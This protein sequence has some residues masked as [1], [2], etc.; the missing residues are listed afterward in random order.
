M[1]CARGFASL[2]VIDSRILGCG[3]GFIQSW[4]SRSYG[5]S[6]FVSDGYDQRWVSRLYVVYE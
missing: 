4:Y 2:V 1:G 3:G 5:S 6:S